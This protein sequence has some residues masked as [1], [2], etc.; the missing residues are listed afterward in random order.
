MDPV[1]AWCVRVKSGRV[2]GGIGIADQLIRKYNNL[3]GEG[4]SDA[5]A[6]DLR[7][8]VDAVARPVLDRGARIT[9]EYKRVAE[10]TGIPFE[11]ILY[12]LGYEDP[13]AIYTPGSAPAPVAEPVW[14]P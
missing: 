5:G 9:G 1:P 12:G 4:F 8:T 13:G 11:R 10:I 7:Q 6:Q 2:E 14:E 3:F